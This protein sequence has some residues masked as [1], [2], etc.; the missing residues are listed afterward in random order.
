[1]S[2]RMKRTKPTPF[3]IGY[4]M[5]LIVGEGSFTGDLRAPVLAVQLHENDPLPLL[6]LQR[7]LGGRIYGPYHYRQKDGS[8]RHAIK[9]LLRGRALAAL[10]PAIH[11]H[12][13]PSR[14]R[15]QFELWLMKYRLTSIVAGQL[16]LSHVEHSVK[17][18]AK[19]APLEQLRLVDAKRGG[20]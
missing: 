9:W 16:E 13:P 18:S 3:Q 20:A 6:A 17:R 12:L 19:T 5:G 4:L 14:K 10:L 11:R 7:V 1:M 2:D 8:E 15:E